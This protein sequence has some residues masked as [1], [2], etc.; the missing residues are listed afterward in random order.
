MSLESPRPIRWGEGQGEGQSG[1]IIPSQPAAG[2]T[3][4]VRN[5]TPSRQAAKTRGRGLPRGKAGS[6]PT[7][8][9]AC[10]LARRFRQSNRHHR[11]GTS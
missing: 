11:H 6:P 9:L 10:L 5:L 1:C 3:G 7:A 4:P 2:P 8:K